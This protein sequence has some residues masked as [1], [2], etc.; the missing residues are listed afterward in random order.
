MLLE[1]EFNAFGGWEQCFGSLEVMYL[2]SGCI[3]LGVW[4]SSFWS[5]LE[6]YE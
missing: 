1:P 2:E 3:V 5:T 4:E 6:L